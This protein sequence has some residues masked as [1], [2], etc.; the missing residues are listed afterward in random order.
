MLNR[1]NRAEQVSLGPRVHLIHQ[2]LAREIVAR[3]RGTCLGWA[4]L[5]IQPGLQIG[6]LWFLFGS[7]L[8]VRLEGSQ[9]F[10]SYFLVAMTI[11][12]PIQ[13]V[14]LRSLTLLSDYGAI[15]QRTVFP[16]YIL[17]LIP[18]ILSTLVFV[19]IALVTAT[20]MG[21]WGGFWGGLLT[22][23][24][25]F[26][27]LIP[28][29]YGLSILGLFFLEARQVA[30]FFLTLVMY[31]SPILYAPASYPTW[32]SPFEILNPLSDVIGLGE[33]LVLEGRF[34]AS[35]ALRLIGEWVLMILLVWPAFRRAE[36]YIREE[37]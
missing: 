29:A 6:A 36:P 26:L 9:D 8:K 3:T 7:I 11:W 34:E 20:L 17:P 16:I 19:P 33:S 23:G 4:W 12:L 1:F 13:D 21:G 14:C 28:M 27:G 5:F 24:V 25:V 31:L 35:R 22:Q 18:A 30:P 37:L 15:Y 32:L 2:L 10:L